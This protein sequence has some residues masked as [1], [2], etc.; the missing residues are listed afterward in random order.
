MDP[1]LI[2]LAILAYSSNRKKQ[3]ADTPGGFVKNLSTG[4][5]A[6]STPG[7]PL[8]DT[9]VRINGADTTAFLYQLPGD[10]YTT[11]RVAVSSG[12]NDPTEMGI[13]AT[14]DAAIRIIQSNGWTVAHGGAVLQLKTKPGVDS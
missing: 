12:G 11:T 9:G 3:R 7:H 4:T 2:G 8:Q 10:G 5:F 1:I 14:P 13:F 6:F